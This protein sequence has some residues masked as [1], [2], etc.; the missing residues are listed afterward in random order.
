MIKL[1]KCLCVLA[2]AF[3]SVAS[4]CRSN[5]E[6]SAVPQ[7]NTTQNT[8]TAQSQNATPQSAPENVV[9]NEA[10]ERQARDT[11]SGGRGTKMD[12]PPDIR[13]VMTGVSLP[14]GAV[15][16]FE[17]LSYLIIPYYNFSGTVQNGYMVVN[18]MLADEVLD[19]FAE[20]Y[21][22]KYPIERME[23][24][25]YYDGSDFESIEANNT[26]SF[27]YRVS[28]ANSGKLSAHAYG[29]AID[30]N[31]QINP[32]VG[33]DGTGSHQNA[34]EYWNRNTDSWTSETAKKAFIG[35]NTAIY[36]VFVNKHGGTW[37][38]SW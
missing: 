30:I 36:D 29:C 23:I 1:K 20:L 37:G 2:I 27:N 10:S 24:I 35:E 38:G 25:D 4:G 34:K 33:Q 9:A 12:I 8:N 17:D 18:S 6:G 19:I 11:T 7:A 28:T 3:V 21:R 32:Y 13:Q 22:L 26:S 14:E 16:T 15:I 31:P 5:A